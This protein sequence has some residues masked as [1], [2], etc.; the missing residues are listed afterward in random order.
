VSGFYGDHK[1][2]DRPIHRGKKDGLF[3]N[4]TV[5]GTFCAIT[6]IKR[7]LESRTCGSTAHTFS[8]DGGLTLFRKVNEYNSCCT[9]AKVPGIKLEGFK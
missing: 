3:I 7:G 8:Y 2:T 5:L 4:S 9:I 1:L 6:D